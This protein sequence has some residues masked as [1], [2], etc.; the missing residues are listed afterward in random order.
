MIDL[1]RQR[2]PVLLIHGLFSRPA[3]LQPWI[4]RLA[5]A[6]FECHCVT[7]PGR[8]PIEEDRLRHTDLEEYFETVLTA[9]GA[10]DEA[11]IVIGH[12]LGGLLAQKLAAATD[13]AALVLLASV[14]PGMLPAQLVA[15]PHLARL[16]PAIL[17]GRPVLPSE[18][19]MRNVPLSPL[20]RAEQD[21]ILPEL[22]PDS[23]RVF[24]SL[25]LGSRQTKVDTS[26]VTCPVLCVSGG[27]DRNVSTRTS[28][29]IARRYRATH[30]HHRG[31][32][33]WI[34][35]ESLLD[36]VFPGVLTWIDE[37]V[38]ARSPR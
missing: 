6:G 9:H 4:G 32:P 31:A 1:D 23:A 10:L 35:A 21:V 26:A 24:R 36:E 38:A 33:H 22:V 16:M 13:C 19:T 11:P 8:D 18:S 5:D 20:D 29:R 2:P 7:L 14:P 37:H 30:Q 27:S 3:L 28:K 25:L 17:A 12:S 34:I 15:L